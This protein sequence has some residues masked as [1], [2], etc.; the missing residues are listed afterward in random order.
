MC[1]IA[2]QLG[3]Y[4]WS[5]NFSKKQNILNKGKQILKLSEI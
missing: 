5:N 3:K 2:E 4:F 1:C